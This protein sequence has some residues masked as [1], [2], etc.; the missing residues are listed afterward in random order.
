MAR[1]GLADA[2]TS[3]IA[4]DNLKAAEF[5]EI[6]IA[7]ST[8]YYFTNHDED[9]HWGGPSKFY[10]SLPIQRGP[11]NTSM[12]LES[13]SV[14]LVLTNITSDLRDVVENNLLD[15]VG[16]VIRRALWNTAYAAGMEILIFSGTGTPAYNRDVLSLRCISLMDSLNIMIP[17]NLYQAPCNWGLFSSGC[18]LAAASFKT[19]TTATSTSSNY[20]TIIDTGFTVPSGDTKKFHQGRVV[21]TGGNNSG[22]KRTILSAVDGLITINVPFPNIVQSGDSFDYYPGC[23]KNPEICNSRFSNIDNFFGFV[24]MPTPEE[25]IL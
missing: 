4:G 7:T 1:S 24:Y 20:Y 18:G 23:S 10:K 17:R 13:D 3:A 6:T 8:T 5:F 22:L 15:N 16:V 9:I 12:N 21:M 14:D 11:I 25:A 2:F 19:S